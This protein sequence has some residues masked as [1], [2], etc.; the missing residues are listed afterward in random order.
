MKR[1]LKEGARGGPDNTL[2]RENLM[3]RE[4]K[5]RTN[6]VASAVEVALESHEERIESLFFALRGLSGAP[7]NL[8]KR[9]LK[10][11]APPFFPRGSLGESN[12]ERIERSGCWCS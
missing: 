2:G 7:W 11:P 5:A 6:E 1:E 3:K 9:E 4:L 8:M 10:E 12:E